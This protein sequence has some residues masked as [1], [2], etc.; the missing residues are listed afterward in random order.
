M[1]TAIP[2]A[3]LLIIEQCG[4]MSTVEQAPDVNRA[5]ATWLSR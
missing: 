2:N 5:L 4:H 3:E 1:H